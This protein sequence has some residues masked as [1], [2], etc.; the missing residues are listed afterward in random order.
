MTG[1]RKKARALLVV[2]SSFYVENYGK[3]ATHAKILYFFMKLSSCVC[4]PAWIVKF[5][6]APINNEKLQ[7]LSAL[8]AGFDQLRSSF[9]G[10]EGTILLMGCALLPKYCFKVSYHFE[11]KILKQD[12]KIISWSA[13]SRS[14]ES[15]VAPGLS[16]KES[17]GNKTTVKS[18]L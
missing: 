7:N 3:L 15:Q 14:I 8:C 4:T 13:H 12:E 5:L 11:G 17:V 2:D 16:S 9:P 1:E 6:F 18:R 10:G